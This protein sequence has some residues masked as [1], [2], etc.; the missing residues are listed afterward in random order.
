MSPVTEK[1]TTSSIF[2]PLVATVILLI[3]CQAIA[4]WLK[5][6]ETTPGQFRG[7][8]EF[9]KSTLL[10]TYGDWTLQTFSSPKAA[11]ER[12]TNQSF[13]SHSWRYTNA[14]GEALVSC[15]QSD[16]HDWHE[17]TFCYHQTGWTI[18]SRTS[19][20]NPEFDKAWPYVVVE[21]ERQDTIALLVFSMFFRDGS[22]IMPPDRSAEE[23]LGTTRQGRWA[24]RQN[25]T[26]H[27]THI[28]PT[29]L[30]LQCQ[31][32]FASNQQ[33]SAKQQQETVRLH[34]KTRRQLRAASKLHFDVG[35]QRLATAE[36][37]E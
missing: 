3:G 4:S 20:T 23:T 28:D 27:A 18:R 35:S 5:S 37:T 2:L 36:M 19:Y 10:S 31:V 33:I 16:W 26:W 17:L 22:P 14:T 29:M 11:D 13:S 21:L 24:G 7:D 30:A 34:H 1:N 15:D 9:S 12:P 8:I 32:L 6:A 25:G